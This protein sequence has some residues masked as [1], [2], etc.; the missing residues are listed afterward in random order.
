MKI[1]IRQ[2]VIASSVVVLSA[3]LLAA[4]KEQRPAAPEDYFQ[5]E[6]LGS[7]AISPDGE[8]LA[9]V[10]KR[11]RAS[12][13]ASNSGD[14]LTQGAARSDIWLVS[15]RGGQ[16]RNLTN[17]AADQAGYWMP[18]WSPDGER[19][20]LLSTNGGNV[21]LWIWDTRT[22][23]SRQ[24]TDRA[25]DPNATR[26]L[27]WTSPTQLLVPVLPA[28]E[29]PLVMSAEMLSAQ[30][31]MREWPKAWAGKEPTASVLE[32]GVPVNLETRPQQDLLLVDVAAAAGRA[33]AKS[34]L[35]AAGFDQLSRASGASI[36]AMLTKSGVVRPHP[37]T[38]LAHT[39]EELFDVAIVD[40]SRGALQSRKLG[41]L[42]DVER[43][44]MHW[45]PDGT[46]LS[47][48]ARAADASD[49]SDAADVMF[50]CRIATNA[51][52]AVGVDRLELP[53][54]YRRVW[55][56]AT[57]W[58]SAPTHD[59]LVLSPGKGSGAAARSQWWIANEHGDVHPI[60]ATWKAPPAQ[61][62]REAGGR[63]FVGVADGHLWRV[64]LDGSPARDLTPNADLKLTSIVWPTDDTTELTHV[65]AGARNGDADDLYRVDL[66][67]E[68]PAVIA[69]KKPTPGATLAAYAPTR[70]VAVFT[71]AD[72]NGT[73]L[74][75]S[76]PAFETT[77]PVL[78]ANTFLRDVA[79]GEFKS[80]TYRSLDGRELHGWIL[81]PVGYTQGQR[82]AMVAWVYAGNVYGDRVT[83][84]LRVGFPNWLSPQLLAAHGYAVL[85]PSIPLGPFGEPSDPLLDI[86]KGVLPAV[87]MAIDLGIAD[88]NRL[89][90]MG[91]SFGGFTTY[92]LITQTTRFKAAVAMAGMVD[93]ATAYGTF[94]ARLRYTAAP[95]EELFN[96][97]LAES[98]QARMANPPWK[99][100]GR[101][102][103]NSPITYVDRV[104][105]PV[106]IIHGDLDLV[107]MQQAELFFQ[108]LYR[109]NKR[110]R[111]VRYWGE[112]HYIS[113]MANNIDMWHRVYAWFDDLLKPTPAGAGTTH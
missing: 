26:E 80:I 79:E 33:N 37:D 65:I 1:D 107:P 12:A 35:T 57:I 28:G 53:R 98:G 71:S 17:G 36:F 87:D 43:S 70:S 51:C 74:W 19:L 111:F 44:T 94:D 31:A 81:L 39:K 29:Q 100:Q 11:S 24:V 15:T 2:I 97:S 62:V 13:P 83:P 91:Q 72:R 85:L 7:A 90:V 113:S 22:G 23:R 21:H 63:T 25:V 93:M 95:Q 110:A 88:P 69:L 108:A 30:V 45:A 54:I 16:P 14:I 56:P 59:L 66:S 89:G 112:T 41:N 84:D 103:R 34:I 92:S 20:A 77:T 101:Y 38:L 86:A 49:T 61:L 58:S 64:P 18:S 78:E 9:Y 60:A 32:S 96:M 4:P 75:I 68:A 82:Y 42:K 46:E 3:A 5:L 47:V 67:T 10:F 73:G 55:R 50:R 105:T 76:R 109:Q 27:F 106:L 102:V 48:V 104:E 8:S 99:D 40:G 6:E 52:V